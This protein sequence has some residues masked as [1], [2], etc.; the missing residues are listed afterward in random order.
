MQDL[1][2][3]DGSAAFRVQLRRERALTIAREHVAALN[4]TGQ[5][6]TTEKTVDQELRIA[7]FLLGRSV[8]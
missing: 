1:P 4:G 2:E 6:A 7:Q 3:N 8:Y 5:Q